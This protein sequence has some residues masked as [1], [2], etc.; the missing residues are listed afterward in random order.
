[1]LALNVSDMKRPGGCPPLWHW[2]DIVRKNIATISLTLTEAANI[3]ADRDKWQ[4]L[5]ADNMFCVGLNM[6]AAQLLR[7]DHSIKLREA[8]KASVFEDLSRSWAQLVS[9]TT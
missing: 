3:T 2:I 5:V 7:H 1:M 6:Y 4:E 9:A 8:W